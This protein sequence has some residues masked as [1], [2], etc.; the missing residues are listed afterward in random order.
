VLI[1]KIYLRGP[2]TK[3][4]NFR[5][6]KKK[7][8]KTNSTRFLQSSAWRTLRKKALEEYG[9]RCMCCERIERNTQKIQV[10]HICPRAT[11]PNLALVFNNLQILCEYCNSHK[12]NRMIN[13]KEQSLKRRKQKLERRISAVNKASVSGKDGNSSERRS[14]RPD[15]ESNH[16][17]AQ[18]GV[19]SPGINK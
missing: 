4:K 18:Q 11:H 17:R 9:P 19:T 8:K 7:P 12:G 14:Q 3:S 10:D 6:K 13:F 1:S 2:K 16:S 15:K 5:K